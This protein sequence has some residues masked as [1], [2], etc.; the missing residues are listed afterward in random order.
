MAAQNHQ[1][2][3]PSIQEI[4]TWLDSQMLCTIASH[5]KEGYP[6]AASVAFSQT[7]DLQFLIITDSM[8]RKATNIASNSRVALTITN[9]DDR[10]TV[11]LEGDARQLTW[12]AFKQYEHHHYEKLPFSLPFQDIPGQTPFLIDPVHVRF[13]DASVRPW[14]LTDYTF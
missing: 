7:D 10:Y 13:T 1:G 12:D 14:L 6:N 3:K 9:A 5:G 4:Y 8:S 2:L 11:Q